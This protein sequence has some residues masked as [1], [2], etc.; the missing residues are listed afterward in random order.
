MAAAAGTWHQGPGSAACGGTSKGHSGGWVGG[1]RTRVSASQPREHSLAHPAAHPCTPWSATRPCLH[2]STQW[3]LSPRSLVTAHPLLHLALCSS[4]SAHPSHGVLA[5]V[6]GGSGS[7]VG[8][9]AEMVEVV[10]RVEGRGGEATLS[11]SKGNV[12]CVAAKVGASLL[13]G[14]RVVR[15]RWVPVEG[16]GGR[17]WRWWLGGGTTTRWV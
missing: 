8:A 15:R 13:Q 7:G 6:G 14:R 3:W 4:N 12:V 16:E 11:A 10:G 5:N 17:G 1:G 2:S 9:N